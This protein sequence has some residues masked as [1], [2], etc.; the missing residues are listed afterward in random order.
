MALFMLARSSIHMNS[1]SN[2]LSASSPRARF[3]GMAVGKVISEIV[4]KPENAMKFEF[5]DGEK[6]EVEYFRKLMQINDKLG[7]IGD[8]ELSQSGFHNSHNRTSK[9]KDTKQKS[10]DKFAPV[11]GQSQPS[12][13]RIVE[14]MDDSE[15]DDDLIPYAK[16]DS[17]PE[18]ESDDPT[19]V[20]R[21][22]PTAPV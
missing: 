11:G 17:D 20:Q 22:K 15:E 14:V 4:D 7:H 6:E 10:T 8:L 9:T 3:L 13:P 18:D 1:I 12:G 21:N 16:P 5:E 19:A 2:R